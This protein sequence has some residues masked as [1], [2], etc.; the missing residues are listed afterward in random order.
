MSTG[1]SSDWNCE[2]LSKKFF[3]INSCA[4]I[5]GAVVHGGDQAS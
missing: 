5:E 1:A 2:E 3:E 4:V